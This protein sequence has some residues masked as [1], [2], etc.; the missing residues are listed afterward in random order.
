MNEDLLEILNL[1]SRLG[2]HKR[3]RTQLL[4]KLLTL[5]KSGLSAERA[6]LLTLTESQEYQ[7]W[8]SQSSGGAL[9]ANAAGNISHHALQMASESGSAKTFENTHQD[10]RF[11]TL[12]EEESGNKV[13]WIRVFPLRAPMST[14]FVYLD[15]RFALE[16]HKDELTPLEEGILELL[17]LILQE[18][19]LSQSIPF[20]ARQ[21]EVVEG[22][23]ST[24]AETCNMTVEDPVQFGSFVTRSPDLIS[25]VGELGKITATDIPILISGESGTGKELLAQ[26]VHQQSGRE[27]DFIALHCG[28]INESLAEVEL[29]GHEKGAFTGADKRRDGRFMLADKGTIFLDEVGEVPLPM[30]AKLLRAIQEREIQRVGSDT[31]L[32][33]DVRII[34]ATNKDLVES[35]KQGEFRED[36]YYSEIKACE[37]YY[38]YSNQL[39]Y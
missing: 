12:A 35:V 27:G 11:R 34:A 19:D 4:G 1:L 23:D 22:T 21:D 3:Y 25:E 16:E 9:V 38:D 18:E 10:R 36:L 17:R 39:S 6:F 33:A 30:Q 15:S 14:T 28:T 5:F 7:V 8:C 32:H 20:S 37:R 24:T 29:F 2:D 13:R 26:M 31:I